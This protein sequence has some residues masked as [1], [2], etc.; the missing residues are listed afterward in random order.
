M[1]GKPILVFEFMNVIEANVA[2]LA[3]GCYIK[4]QNVIRIK[5]VYFFT[6]VIEESSQEKFGFGTI[7]GTSVGAFLVFASIAILFVV[8]YRKRLIN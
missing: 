6:T 5:N 1:T 8:F 2:Q 7:V 4:H 3:V